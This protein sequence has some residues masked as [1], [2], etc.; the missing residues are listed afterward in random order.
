LKGDSIGRYEQG[1]GYWFDFRKENITGRTTDPRKL[2]AMPKVLMRKT[3]NRIIATYDSS[4][5]FPEQSLYFL[6]DSFT[7]MSLKF[8]LGTLNSNLLGTY[9]DAKSLTNKDSIAQVKKA[10]LDRLPLRNIDFSNPEDVTRHDQM[11]G[12]VDR[13]LELY[14][15]VSEAKVPSE[16]TRIQGQIADTDKR[17]DQLVYELYSLTDEE[18]KI[19]ESP[20]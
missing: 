3:G 8:L 17:I 6:Y 18:I 13:M 12:F 7:Q 14:E 19:V 9:F 5:V 10:D 16:R 4:G 20:H 1:D 11:V 2:G 15:R